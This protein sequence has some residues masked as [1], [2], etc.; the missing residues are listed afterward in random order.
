[1]KSEK[2]IERHISELE[3]KQRF[4]QDELKN[5]SLSEGRQEFYCDGIEEIDSQLQALRWV[6]EM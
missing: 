1:M 6:L 3:E 2:E 4:Y 5:E